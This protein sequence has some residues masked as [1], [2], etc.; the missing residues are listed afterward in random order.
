MEL[1]T[2]KDEPIAGAITD[3]WD[4]LSRERDLW[5]NRLSDLRSY[6]FAP[7]TSHTEVTKAGWQ[8]KA[9]VPKIT[10]IY[11]NLGAQY[12]SA[13]FPNENWVTFEGYKQEDM[14]T[15]NMVEMYLRHK[16][17]ESDFITV[18]RQLISDWIWSGQTCAGVEHIR[19]YTQSNVNP[20]NKILKYHGA[21]S[22]RVS[23]Y[24]YVIESRATSY[25]ESIF[26]R[27]K[28][29]PRASLFSHNNETSF[30]QYD[31][32]VLQSAKDV[33]GWSRENEDALKDIDLAIDGFSTPQDY[34]QS[35]MVEIFEFWGDF[36]NKDTGEYLKNQTIGIIDRIGV[37]WN[38]PNPMWN[39]K[40]PYTVTGWRQRP[41]NLTAQ[42]PLEM[43]VGLQYRIDF[44][45]NAKADILDL[46]IHPRVDVF[47]DPVDEYSMDPGSIN[48][49]GQD[50]KV[51]YNSPDAS[52]L[53]VSGEIFRLMELME[54]MAGAPK[55]TAGLRTPGEKTAFE[56]SQLNEGASKMFLE[57]TKH[58]ELSF[59]KPHL[60]NYYTLTA[61]YFSVDDTFKVLDDVTGAMQIIPATKEQ[62][63][64][65]G[66]FKL[67][68]SENYGK[69]N[70]RLLDL[71]DG[72]NLLY[73]NE[74]TAA[75]V[76][77]IALDNVVA[78]ELDWENLGI[79]KP[80]AG[81]TE[82]IDGQ[83][84]MQLHQQ[85]VQKD[86]GQMMPQGE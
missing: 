61:M 72:I 32:K 80:Y 7:D 47:G 57:K 79:I 45:E 64:R 8:N 65:D 33:V 76:D 1:S 56:V 82:Q 37:L 77:S 55:Q 4:Q 17:R 21:K 51:Q 9:R 41:D 70:Q 14:N 81:L 25:D 48:E 75:H 40:R 71:R 34:F 13:L 43:L 62:V 63:I 74:R 68:G 52:V 24:D 19:E 28:L 78:R 35:G 18:A 39:G 58:F 16:L 10:Q 38:Q 67:H 23:P 83:M 6:L 27:R 42:G 36:Y 26:I 54:E 5:L 20:D 85:Q 49:M 31:E 44:L 59:L 30:L 22:F 46:T 11:D 69:K 86:F 73:S 84:A 3:L 53:N 60:N 50:A 66:N 15:D 12:L 29:V 2:Y